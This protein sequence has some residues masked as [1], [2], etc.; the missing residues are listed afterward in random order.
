MSMTKAYE[1]QIFRRSEWVVDAIFDSRDRALEEARQLADRLPLA[2]V[3]VTEERFD[4]DRGT[5]FWFVIFQNRA[6]PADPT[7]ARLQRRHRNQPLPSAPRPPAATGW[8]RHRQAASVLAGLGIGLLG[9]V[10]L[11]YLAGLAF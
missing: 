11:A 1:L 6:L 8:C 7:E 10:A 2:M 9:G 5:P 4:P 3:R